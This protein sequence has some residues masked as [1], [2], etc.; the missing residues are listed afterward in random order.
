MLPL[1]MRKSQSE[2]CFEKVFGEKS[3]EQAK[4]LLTGALKTV[5]DS[6]VIVN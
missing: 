6:E 1:Q 4:M 3:V 2:N 5:D